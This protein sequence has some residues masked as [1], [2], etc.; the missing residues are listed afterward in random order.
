[1][2]IVKTGHEIMLLKRAAEISNSCIPVIEKSLNEGVTEKELARRVRRKINSQCATLSFQT[3]VGTGERSRMIHTKPHVTGRNIVGL[4]YIDFG[5]RYKGYASDVTV[6]FIKGKITP[7]QKRVV[8]VVLRAYDVGVKSVRVGE[9]C[10]TSFAKVDS[11]L[12]KHGYKMQHG[13]GHGIGLK[14]HERPSLVAAT[15]KLRGKRKKRWE[16]IKKVTFQNGMVFTIE[17]G[18]YTKKFGCRIENDFLLQD[19][20]LVQLTKSRMLRA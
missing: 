5:A 8:D 11:F 1:M 17:P 15:K 4:G 10:W 14:I 6:P 19:G 18:V 7:K 13:L 3:L 2:A 16:R 9:P 12:R 20:K